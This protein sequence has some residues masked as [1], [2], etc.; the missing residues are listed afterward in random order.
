[1]GWIVGILIVSALVVLSG[2]LLFCALCW[3][4]AAMQ[5]GDR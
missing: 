3:G 2:F 5:D 4:M 1:M